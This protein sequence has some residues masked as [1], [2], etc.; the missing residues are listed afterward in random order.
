VPDELANHV[1]GPPEL[2]DPVAPG[3][4]THG[5]LGVMA[6]TVNRAAGE[7]ESC[8]VNQ[9]SAG[10]YRGPLFLRACYNFCSPIV[11]EAMV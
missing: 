2:F 9:R 8:R 10:I 6:D 5:M 3:P 11:A 7:Q 4:V 1:R